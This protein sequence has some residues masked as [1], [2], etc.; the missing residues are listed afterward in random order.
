MEKKYYL[1]KSPKSN[2]SLSDAI[3]AACD[4]LAINLDETVEEFFE[5][6]TDLYPLLPLVSKAPSLTALYLND[7]GGVE[8][9]RSCNDPSGL[10][11]FLQDFDAK[12][13]ALDNAEPVEE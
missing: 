6:N 12:C 11:S 9:A 10:N 5:R 4:S 3:S 13:D 2:K 1:I 8:I 7:D